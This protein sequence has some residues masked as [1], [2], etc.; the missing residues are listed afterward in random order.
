M[1]QLTRCINLDW[2]ELY[3]SE[4]SVDE[5]RD[6]D[7]FQRY[8]YVV[9]RRRYGTPQYAEMFTIYEGDAPFVEVRRAPYSLRREGGIF[10]PTA[11]HLR[12]HNRTC[13]EADP[14]GH[15]RFFMVTHGYTFHSISR[16]D[17]AFDFV[18]F[19]NDEYEPDV[20]MTPVDFVHRY[21]RAEVSKVNQSRVSAHGYDGWTMRKWNSLKWGS[22][23]S[24]I[25]TKFYCKTLELKEVEDKPYIRQRW[26]EAGF[27]PSDEVWRI[28][29]SA[30]SQMQSMASLKGGHTFKKELSAYDSG[31][32]LLFQF[33]QFYG[34]YF[35][36]RRV[37]RN[38]DGSLKRKYECPR[39]ELFRWN[40][41]V[42][43]KPTRNLTLSSK[44]TRT[45]R[46][47]IKRL[48]AIYHD[49]NLTP[50]ERNA[51]AVM[52]SYFIDTL[53]LTQA[54]QYEEVLALRNELRVP[55]LAEVQW[56]AERYTQLER[57][58]MFLLMQ[59]YGIHP[60][61]EGCPF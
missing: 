1:E 22:P 16:I 56:Q 20:H 36:F 42:V 57:S 46:I 40:V 37:I 10:E 31:R 41:S 32:K 6:A 14:I 30:S 5:P 61:P 8:G 29:F 39:L 24:A 23:R 52:L 13:Y 53:M 12:L 19:D 4:L 50:K 47:L 59:K 60:T 15:L 55:S 18:H 27:Q 26:L 21:M 48:K 3:C 45:L 28:E 38:R 7:Y 34:K 35:D 25:T 44:P 33:V 58:K 11:C 43:L 54:E 17:I 51:A 9:K 2:L 49:V